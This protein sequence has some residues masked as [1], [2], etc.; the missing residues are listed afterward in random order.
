MRI[1]VLADRRL[2]D[3]NLLQ[4]Q[5]KRRRVEEKRS[6]LKVEKKQISFRN[7]MT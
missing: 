2:K 6:E 1:L 5:I 3:G 4:S 7:L